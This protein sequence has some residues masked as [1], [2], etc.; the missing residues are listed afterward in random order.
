LLA[1]TGDEL[2]DI[3][4]NA[5]PSS[6]STK[7][8]LPPL[9]IVLSGVEFGPIF[10]DE[11]ILNKHSVVTND[12]LLSNVLPLPAGVSVKDFT[13]LR[14][15]LVD[16]LFPKGQ[17]NQNKVMDHPFEFS[18]ST[19]TWH[20]KNNDD[21]SENIP[22]PVSYEAFVKRLQDDPPRPEL[23]RQ[24]FK[25]GKPKDARNP[26]KTVQKFQDDAELETKDAKELKV[27]NEQLHE[28]V[29]NLRVEKLE[30]Q[31]LLLSSQLELLRA[32]AQI[33]TSIFTAGKQS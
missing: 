12:V 27:R 30:A 8:P 2:V 31:N 17:K 3:R 18:T 24:I 26:V 11:D 21:D 5:A 6:R 25:V 22:V 15:T 29:Q 9:Q 23:L 13:I 20:L 16:E 28:E 14:K 19:A 4:R 32:Q 33:G 10:T 7:P 1:S